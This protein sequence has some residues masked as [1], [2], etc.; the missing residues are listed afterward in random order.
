MLTY[1]DV[2]RWEVLWLE[3]KQTFRRMLTYA[4]VCWRMLTYADVCR[5]EVLWL[6]PKQMFRPTVRYA[7]KVLSFPTDHPAYQ[8]DVMR[9]ATGTQFPCFTSTRVHIPTQTALPQPE[10]T[11]EE[12][13]VLA[14]LVQKHTY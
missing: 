7:S 3:P 13:S 6:E 11:P 4:D 5:W 12:L 8:S 2:C 9:L 10:T 1:A 14:L